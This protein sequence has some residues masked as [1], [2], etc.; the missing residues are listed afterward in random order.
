MKKTILLT[1]TLILLL[2]CSKEIPFTET[3]VDGVKIIEN[4]KAGINKELTYKID[5]VMTIENNEEDT[6]FVL[7]FP[8][9]RADLNSDLDKDGNLYVVDNSKNKYTISQYDYSGKKIREIKKKYAPLRRSK[10]DMD[11]INDALKKVSQQMGG[12]IEFKEVSNLRS[13]ITQMFVDSNENLWV[14]VN[15]S[16]FK[17]E[18]QDFDIFNKEGHFLTTVTVPELTGFKLRSKG[19]YI[20]AATSIEQNYSEGGKTDVVIKVFKLSING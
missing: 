15:E 18:G 11:G 3:E 7:N 9:Q 1:L 5:E 6:T 12:M 17:E 20:I 4:S 14:S 16:M 8:Q 13:A 2:S 19:K 10:E